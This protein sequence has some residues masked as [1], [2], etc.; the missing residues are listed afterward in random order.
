M[1]S[2]IHMIILMQPSLQQAVEFYELLGCKLNF[3]IPN[4]W[5]ELR[6]PDG[7]KIGLCPIDSMPA[8]SVRTGLV[9]QVDDL[10]ACYEL[11]KQKGFSVGEPITKIHG[12][13]VKVV[14]PENNGIDLYQPTPSQVT[15]L[16]K[17]VK[18]DTGCKKPGGCACKQAA[19]AH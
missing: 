9:F 8:Q 1:I 7:F 19:S 13:M 2:Q 4:K 14:D 3:D 18:K 11:L 5:V 16:I 12:T 10:M 15:E 6:L 17:Q